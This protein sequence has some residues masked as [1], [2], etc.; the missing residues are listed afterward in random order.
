MFAWAIAKARA[1]GC[2]VVQLTPDKQRPDARTFYEAL[3][4]VASHEG[5]KLHLT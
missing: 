5:M 3:G 1:A 4:F 2:H